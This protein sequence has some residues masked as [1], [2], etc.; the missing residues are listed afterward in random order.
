M[1]EGSTLE[2]RASEAARVL[3]SR[4]GSYHKP[5]VHEVRRA[6][7]RAGAARRLSQGWRNSLR[8][9]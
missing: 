4:R 8:P 3:N 9:L 7:Q 5:G 2:A 1:Q 6:H